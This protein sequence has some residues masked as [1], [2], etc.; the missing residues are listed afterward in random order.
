MKFSLFYHSLVSDWNHGNAHFL[1]GIV[2]E[3]IALGHEV[4][5]FEPEDSW[6]KTNLL[7]DHGVKAI[8]EFHEYYPELHSISYRQNTLDLPEITATSDVVIVHEWNEP[9]LVNELGRLRDAAQSGREGKFC[10]LFH[11]THHRAVSDEEWLKRFRLDAYDG[12][13]AFGEILSDVYRRHGWHNHVW[14]WHE[15]AD[16]RMFYPRKPD[17]A[18]PSGD[19]VWVGNWGDDERTAELETFL[20]GPV[21]DLGLSCQIHGVRYPQEVLARLAR[22]GVEYMGWLPNY[23]AAEVFANHAVT[24]HVPRRYYAENLPGIPTIRPF[25]VMACGLPLICAP[26]QDSENLFTPGS[27]YLVAENGEQMRTHLRQIINDPAF[28]KEVSA[29]A[30]E[31]IRSRHTC[32]HR[33]AQLMAIIE[34]LGVGSASHSISST[35]TGSTSHVYS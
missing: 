26:W 12:V 8:E 10:L 13:L 27:D 7:Q 29:R 23:R 14:T 20:F 9:W 4:L 28:A 17:P 22:D 30:L 32:G 25:E 18:L 21:R 11:D 19:V 35:S 24:V 31:T 1:R 16:I 34:S 2:S 5:V 33:V 15:A 6:S 3:L